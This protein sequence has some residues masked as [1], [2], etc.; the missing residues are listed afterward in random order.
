MPDGP[1]GRAPAGHHPPMQR[2][3]LLRRLVD[4]WLL[5]AGYGSCRAAGALPR[6]MT[7]APRF[8]CDLSATPR[9]LR[10]P[11][12]HCVGSC[13]APTALRAD[14]QQQLARAHAELG[15]RHVRFHG[16][17]SDDMGTLVCQDEKFLFSFFNS[18]RVFDFLR[19]IGMRPVVEL[20]FMPGALS[21]GG[22][23]VFHY[24]ANVTPPKRMADWTLLISKL[25]GHWV[26]RYGLDEVAQWPLEVWNEPN[27]VAFW[28]GGQAQYFELYRATWNAVKAISPRLQVGGPAT[29][30]NGWLDDFERFC[31]ANGCRADFI[32]THYYPTDAFGS[33]DTDTVSQLADAPPHVLRERAREARAAAGARPLYYT[34]WNITS[35]PRDEMHDGPFC[36]ALAARFALDVDDLVDAASWWTFSDIF[37]ENYFPSLPFHGGFGLMNLYGVPKPVYRGFELLGRL[38]TRR[39]TVAGAHPTVEAAVGAGDDE[40]WTAVLLTNVV[41]PRHPIADE[42]AVVRLAGLRGRRARAASVARIDAAHANPKA[43]WLAM[44]APEYPLPH[45]VEALQAASALVDAPLAF[46]TEGD[47]LVFSIA[48]PVDATAL[49]R[50]E[51]EAAS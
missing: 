23:S 22:N 13:H 43:A 31:K 36:A 40:T 12:R 27:L 24:R 46:T 35:N 2:R 18:D 37:E 50:I 10:H 30:A 26:D 7:D 9:P 15:I 47:A 34:E 1:A 3:T 14:W 11:W 33:V 38:G 45:Q 49:V 51:W 19:S 25:V 42:T 29:A 32:S 16:L 41:L 8:D 39:W 5:M 6:A 4:G 44:G 28:T 17:L 21:S 48:L 20:S